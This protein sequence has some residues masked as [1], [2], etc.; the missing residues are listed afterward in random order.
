MAMESIEQ[1]TAGACQHDT[2]LD[3]LAAVLVWEV[4]RIIQGAPLADCQREVRLALGR[5]VEA[6][7]GG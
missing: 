6:A 3:D 7:R 2:P 4:C 1:H 5:L